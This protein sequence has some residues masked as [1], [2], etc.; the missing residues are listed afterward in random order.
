MLSKL[1]SRPIILVVVV[2]LVAATFLVVGSGPETRTVTAHFER[3]VSLYQGSEVR[4]MGVRVGTVKAVVPEG[5]S[6]RVVM[7]YD[8]QYKVPA[9]A[10]A[11]IITP[12]L[13]ADRAA[14]P[15]TRM[16][17]EAS[18]HYNPALAQQS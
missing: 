5:R 7:E 9:D 4:I 12:T 10:R 16:L 2:L 8:E 1:T 14:M 6:V 17:V 18:R 3:T 15:Y 11:A 13:V